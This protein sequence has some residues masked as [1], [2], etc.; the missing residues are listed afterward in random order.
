MKLSFLGIIQHHRKALILFTAILMIAGVIALVQMPRDEFPVFHVRQGIVIGLYPGATSQQVEEQLTKKVESY[1]FQFA[2]VERSKTWSISKEN[3]MVIYVEVSPEEKDPDGFWVKLQ[4]GLNQFKGEL[5]AGVLSLTA[6]NDFGNTSALLLAVESESKTYKEL[7]EYIKKFEDDVRAVPSVSRI[8]RYGMQREQISVYIDDAR[9]TH[10]GIKP[11]VVLA[12]LKPQST[13]SYAGEVD[14][15]RFIYPIHL[16]LSYRTEQDVANQIVYADP[17][18]HVVRIRDVATVVREYENPASWIRVNGKKCL[19]VSLEM[20][21]GENIVH[22]GKEVG[23]EIAKFSRSLPPDI[24]IETISNIPDAV[25]RAVGDF[26]LEFSISIIAVML[27]TVLLLPRRVAL[28]TAVTIPISILITLAIMW[29][30]GMDLQTVSLASLIIVLGMVV[31][32]AIVVID[33]YVEKLDRGLPRS[34]AASRSV[35]ELFASVLSATLILIACFVPIKFFMTGVAGDFVRS[36]PATVSIALLTSLFTAAVL[37]PLMSYRFVHSGI[38][39]AGSGGK[40]G[41]FLNRVQQ[42]YDRMVE[43]AFTMKKR[44]VA[45]GLLSFLLG[46]AFLAIKPQQPFP[47]IERNQFAVEVYLPEGASLGQTD[48]V[49]KDLE[50]LLQRDPRVRTVASFIGTSSPRFHTLYAPN[51]PAKNYGQ[52]VVLT[53]SNKATLAILDEYSRKYAHRYADA[54]IKWKQLEFA[55][56]KTP[57]EIRLSGDSLAALKRSAAAVAQLLQQDPGVTWVRSDAKE[58]RQSIELD[59]HPDEVSRLGYSNAMLG[60]SLMVG[61]QGFPVATLWEGD[62]PVE[63][64]LLVDKRTRSSAAE[65]ANLYVTSPLLLSAVPLRQIA[66]LEPGWSEGEI[67]HR[68]GVRTIT[69]H[70]DLERGIYAAAVFNRVRPQLERLALPDGISLSYG[71]LY[72]DQVEYMTPFYY[73]LAVSIVIIFFILM[74]QFRNLKTSLLIMGTM[75]LTI[76]GASFGI[77]VTGYP[78]SVTA[79]IGVIGL[80]GI[81]VRNGIIYIS[82]AEELRREQ[83]HS[84]EEAAI[85][86]AKRRMRPIFLTAAAA[87]VGVVPM[88]ASGSSLWGPLGSVICF[89]L[90]FGLVLSLLVMPVL[91]YLFHRKDFDQVE[92]G[93]NA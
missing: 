15:G 55:A 41:A 2:A 14:D 85:M 89:G 7:E 61:T 80:M 87:A 45:V 22:F 10:Y 86:A 43:R 50:A 75:P 71:G 28:V 42:S 69:V 56:F 25:D 32:N 46:L 70:A 13:V 74:V 19:V 26:L 47:S 39:A 81:V 37:V 83:G 29:I 52:L 79:L 60:Y 49:I 5:P 20:R 40:K 34:E 51:F 3:Y 62:Y 48:A 18:G 57:I 53:E 6:D 4:H 30:A 84:L 72:K 64:K 66:G 78:F 73:S 17:L 65:I 11:L 58:P 27:V 36:L 44:V 38:S 67:P 1:L 82:Y 77:L 21:N 88:I 16:P 54:N 93:E 91:Y 59:L 68:G 76:F 31:D 33:N 35:T 12:A 8:K 90:I 63:V 24:R 9:L 23:R 92:A